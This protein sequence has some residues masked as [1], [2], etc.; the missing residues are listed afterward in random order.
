MRGFVHGH[1]SLLEDLA[2]RS[3]WEQ[4]TPHLYDREVV[5]PRLV[6][7]VRDGD[8]DSHS[9]TDSATATT[10]AWPLLEEIRGLL[11]AHYRVNFDKIG[12]AYYR[13]GEDSVAWHRDRILRN[14]HFGYVA[15]VSLGEPRTF[16]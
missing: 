7:T 2:A 15:T 16:L 4:T 11:A 6:A 9:D 8:G 10:S 5:T 12:A 3:P 13:T 14:R 1:A